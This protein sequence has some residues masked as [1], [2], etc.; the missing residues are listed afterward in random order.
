M[1]KLETVDKTST[2][3]AEKDLYTAL[4]SAIVGQSFFVPSTDMH[5]KTA[6]RKAFAWALKNDKVVS[7]ERNEKGVRIFMD[8]FKLKQ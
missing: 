2:N 6:V 3:T 8:E 4:E 5:P 1:Y 7:R